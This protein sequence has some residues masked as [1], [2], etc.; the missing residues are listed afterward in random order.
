M[1]LVVDNLITFENL[2][3]DDDLTLYLLGGLGPK[4]DLFVA[5]LIARH[6][7]PTLEE[8]FSLLL[9]HE[10]RLEQI[11][12]IANIHLTNP[13][14]HYT[15]LLPRTCNNDNN[16]RT[17]NSSNFRGTT[18][19]RG[20]AEED[21]AAEMFLNTLVNFAIGMVIV[22]QPATTILTKISLL[23]T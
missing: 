3:I 8:T 4:H 1:K 10:S 16:R 7:V 2:I 17:Q 19:G 18:R 9:S 15:N 14:A 12:V 22:P 23:K 5:N 20:A 21:K 13:T 11:N 6:V